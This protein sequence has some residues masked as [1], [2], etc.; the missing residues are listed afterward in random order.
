MKLFS[1]KFILLA[2]FCLTL[3]G[4]IIAQ[5]KVVTLLQGTITD[6]ESGKPMTVDFEITD[7]T[8]AKTRG[9]SIPNNGS[10]Q[11]V[12]EP[13]NTYTILLS[14]FDI[15]RKVEKIVL[16]PSEKYSIATHDYKVQK[17]RSGMEL[18]ALH[19]FKAGQSNL[20]SEA[21]N[22]FTELK[23]MMK[24]NRSL[25]VIITTFGDE[26]LQPPPPPAPIE[27]TPDP[28]IKKGK[29]K[30]KSKKVE[31]PPSPPPPVE[32]VPQEPLI[33]HL[34]V[35]R[36]EAVKLYLQ[37]VKN[38]DSRIKIVTDEPF[39]KGANGLSPDFKNLQ[40]KVGEVKSLFD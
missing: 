40:V 17:L 4:N 6:E 28:A 39:P 16:P 32:I 27:P 9:K 13:G 37:D 15:L 22:Y 33:D 19:A 34:A 3:S 1:V 12:L 18:N 14:S 30:S 20:S 24:R 5:T 21:T 29:S 8:G 2:V 7:P 36:G 23:E 26:A 38:A 31:P 25:T 11:A 35:Q 10:Y